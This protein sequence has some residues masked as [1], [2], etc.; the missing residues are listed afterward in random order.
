MKAVLRQIIKVALESKVRQAEKSMNDFLLS[1]R[2]FFGGIN[3]FSFS[4]Y[5]EYCKNNFLIK[6][7]E[8]II[9]NI[10]KLTIEYFVDD[11]KSLQRNSAQVYRADKE[12]KIR[13]EIERDIL[14]I[15]AWE[16][17]KEDGVQKF[18]YLFS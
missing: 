11:L 13:Y 16:L 1:E 12:A 6:Q 15:M 14:G 8:N 9:E 18:L 17:S 2:S 5:E 7:V 4:S 3:S 10:D